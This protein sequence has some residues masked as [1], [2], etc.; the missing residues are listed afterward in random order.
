MKDIIYYFQNKLD[1]KVVFRREKY[2][3]LLKD[4]L[5]S[6][7]IKVAIGAR[8][9]GKT[10]FFIDVIQ[11]LIKENKVKLDNVFY[12]NFEDNILIDYCNL[13][14]LQALWDEFTRYV[15]KQW[16][17]VIFLDELQNVDGWEYF[18]RAR[19]DENITLYITWS[20]SKMLSSEIS[21]SLSGRYI[22]IHVFPLDFKEYLDF[23]K[24]LNLFDLRWDINES[25]FISKN[26]DS[27]YMI[28][29]AY[30]T[31]GWYPE[32]M[33]IKN[34]DIKV[35]YLK[36][37]WEKVLLDDIIKR[38]NIRN[39]NSI[40]SIAYYLFS[41]V[42]KVV[43]LNNIEKTMV[44]KWNKINYETLME[45]V[46]YIKNTF[47]ISFLNRFDP[48]LGRVFETTKK[49]YS[50]D[51]GLTYSLQQNISNFNSIYL[52]NTVYNYLLQ[53]WYQTYFFQNLYGKT[54]TNQ[55]EIDFLVV[56]NDWQWYAIQVCR[57]LT[58][59]NQPR[60]LWNF[61]LLSKYDK[62]S[63]NIII[64]MDWEKEDI[65]YKWIDIKKINIFDVLLYWL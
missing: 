1:K 45:Y 20:N 41:S 49:T 52:E 54:D 12:L 19:Y 27:I 35:S 40:K 59:E 62:I 31:F 58:E 64:C 36:W 32:I 15:K 29:N 39:I 46:E 34:E 51:N 42:G 65:K 56:S 6:K 3:D 24:R 33:E 17:V 63:K 61:E 44:S 43:S 10:Y 37:I 8:R 25:N 9:V 7:T 47:M 30:L 4:D 28:F 48:K 50:L 55:K 21:S 26:K 2:F 16:D 14:W 38:Y 57:K 23:G 60:E 11:T 53:N 13:K 22:P 18:V 5:L